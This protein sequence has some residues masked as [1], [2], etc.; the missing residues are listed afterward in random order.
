MDRGA[1]IG[2]AAV[3]AALAGVVG[4]YL[5]L[6]SG[7]TG[8]VAE[9][10]REKPP[11]EA[12]AERG[13]N[14]EAMVRGNTKP[15]PKV[16]GENSERAALGTPRVFDA[17]A[18]KDWSEKRMESARRDRKLAEAQFNDFLGT[19]GLSDGDQLA[20]RD[21]FTTNFDTR[22]NIR[23]QME[24]GEISP[25]EGR[26]LLAEQREGMKTSLLNVVSNEQYEDLLH[27]MDKVRVVLF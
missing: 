5:V 19:S 13:G 1:L 14:S 9:Y 15:E 25:R 23:A 22:D 7:S 27:R 8:D 16:R 6:S 3:V 2:G 4:F 17:K 12:L 20:V 11:V 26:R 18:A 21:V 24:S 10:D